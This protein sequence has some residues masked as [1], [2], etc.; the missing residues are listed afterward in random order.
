MRAK[1]VKAENME[2]V[3]IVSIELGK[4]FFM[5]WIYL[6]LDRDKVY[7]IYISVGY[8]IASCLI[9]DLQIIIYQFFKSSYIRFSYILLLDS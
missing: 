8:T 7:V 1:G 9:S 5:I 6:V 4:Y 3:G 2:I